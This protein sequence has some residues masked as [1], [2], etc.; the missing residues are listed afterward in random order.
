MIPYFQATVIHLGPIPL[1]VWGL[2]VAAGIFAGLWLFSRRVTAHGGQGERV[3]EL[4]VPILVSA[5]IGARLA[6]VFL[7]EASFYLA[8]PLEIIKI[9]H[10]GMS[11]LGGFMGAAVGVWYALWRHQLTWKAFVAEY[12]DD[13]ILSF[14][15]GWGIGRI[16]CFLIHDHPGTLT[17][18]V[19]GVRYP[20][21]VRHDLGL[22]ESLLGFAL[23]GLCLALYPR[24]NARKKGLLATVSLALYALVRIYFDTLR[25]VD[26]RYAGFTPA[27]WGMLAMI[28]SLTGWHFFGKRLQT[29]GKKTND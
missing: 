27:Q 29:F 10:G 6:H 23:F 17:H 16:G 7:Y 22:Y 9:W 4:A 2:M 1:Q 8:Q 12:L 11:S 13:G 14:W 21:G 5:F 20:D 15:L 24:L 26:T 28:L 18:F 25:T 3:W 19:G